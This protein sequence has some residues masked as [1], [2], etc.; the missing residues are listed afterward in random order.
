MERALKQEGAGVIA[1]FARIGFLMV[2]SQRSDKALHPT[3]PHVNEPLFPNDTIQSRLPKPEWLQ[4]WLDEQ[5]R[6]DG[7]WETGLSAASCVTCRVCRGRLS[8]TCAT[9]TVTVSRCR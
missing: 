6:F 4:H 2:S 5:I 9:S 3:N 8:R 7:S 1:A